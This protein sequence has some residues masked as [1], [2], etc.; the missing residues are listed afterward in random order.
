[1]TSS[2]NHYPAVP[3]LNNY[4]LYLFLFVRRSVFWRS[5]D[6]TCSAPVLLVSSS[7]DI[8]ASSESDELD[9]AAD[10]RFNRSKGM[11]WTSRSEGADVILNRH[12]F[13]S[14]TVGPVGSGDSFNCNQYIQN[15]LLD[16]V[17]LK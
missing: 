6:E 10:A 7:D 2:D 16:Q 5:F 8:D 9:T 13:K 11:L 15:I 3:T 12:S 4:G 14:L 1:M 17:F